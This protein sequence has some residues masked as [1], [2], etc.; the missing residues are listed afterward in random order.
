MASF[1]CELILHVHDH[2][3]E[4]TSKLTTYHPQHS[5]PL[6]KLTKPKLGKDPSKSLKISM[7]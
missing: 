4:F 3:D 1:A 7:L 2:Q 6:F 5:P